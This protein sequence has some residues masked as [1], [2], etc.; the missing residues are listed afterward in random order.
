MKA[1]KCFKSTRSLS[2]R[3]YILFTHPI[4]ADYVIWQGGVVQD[5]KEAS[6]KPVE[7]KL[8]GEADYVRYPVTTFS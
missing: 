8:T 6:S 1:C 7:R 2:F 4:P 3:T 5:G